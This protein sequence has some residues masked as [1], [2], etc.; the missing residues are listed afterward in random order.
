[1]KEYCLEV[2]TI[3]STWDACNFY[4]ANPIEAFEKA[5]AAGQLDLPYGEEVDVVATC[6]TGLVIKFRAQL[7]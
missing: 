6:E 5:F 1:M 3:N 7:G 2:W 4:G